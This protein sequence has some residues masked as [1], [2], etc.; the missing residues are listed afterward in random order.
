MLGLLHNEIQQ[1]ADNSRDLKLVIGED[2]KG[3]F[4]FTKVRIRHVTQNKI[5]P[6]IA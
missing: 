6:E 1:L 3:F 2:E 4:L 5:C